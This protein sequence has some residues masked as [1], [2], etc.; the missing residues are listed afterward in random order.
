M[1]TKKLSE[2]LS[3]N[4]KFARKRQG[5]SQAKLAELVGISV[6]FVGEIEIGRKTPSL[7]TLEKLSRALRLEPYELLRDLEVGTEFGNAMVREEI[8]HKISDFTKE[9]LNFYGQVKDDHSEVD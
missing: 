4:I 1:K 3:R 2:I 6:P 8:A 5:L 9:L 7:E